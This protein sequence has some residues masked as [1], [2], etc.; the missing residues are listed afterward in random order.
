MRSSSPTQETDT[1]GPEQ[2]LRP[3]SSK[4]FASLDEAWIEFYH[5]TGA[6]AIE[7]QTFFAGAV[8][9]TMIVRALQSTSETGIVGAYGALLDQLQA[10]DWGE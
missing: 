3:L 8:A 6:L 9:A 5:S 1:G 4:L 2:G 7:R 10:H